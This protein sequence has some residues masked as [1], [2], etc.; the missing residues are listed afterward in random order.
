MVKSR[1]HSFFILSFLLPVLLIYTF[2]IVFP[3]LRALYISLFEWSGL[4]K[5]MTF[6]GIANFERMIQDPSMVFSLKNNL[7]IL[8]IPS[9]GTLIIA[10]ILSQSIYWI[11]LGGE[12]FKLIFFF[13]Y[14]LSTVVWAIVWNFIYNPSF[15][16]INT[17]LRAV[18]LDSLTHA[19]LGEPKLALW[20]IGLVMIWGSVGWYVILLSTAINDIP[21]E[22]YESAMIDGAGL[23]QQFAYITLPLIWGM[24]R[25]SMI[26]LLIYALQTFSLVFVI[27]GGFTD[28]YTEII[29]T[30]MFKQAFNFSNMGYGTAIAVVIFLLLLILTTFALIAGRRER[31][32]F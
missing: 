28:K 32:E 16:A 12:F 6:V 13:P 26:F 22:L 15:G 30:Y 17:F 2:L 23:W 11:P 31:I 21:R 24:I 3:G 5:D 25:I 29:A 27:K 14:L 20:A 10:L 8:F 1:S 7:F 9:L 19:W 18:G 4:S